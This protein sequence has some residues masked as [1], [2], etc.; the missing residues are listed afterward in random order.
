MVTTAGEMEFRIDAESRCGIVD[1]L[2]CPAPGVEMSVRSRVVPNGRGSEYV[3]TQ[4][5]TPG[6]DGET[7][8]QN[9]QALKHELVMLRALLE[10]ECPL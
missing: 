1:F 10:V 4:F 9:I 3:F 8:E 5:Q 6:M 7:F 2:I